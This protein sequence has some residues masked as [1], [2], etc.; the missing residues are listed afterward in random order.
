MKNRNARRWLRSERVPKWFRG[1]LHVIMYAKIS[2]VHSMLRAIVMEAPRKK[3]L[4]DLSISGTHY[5][6]IRNKLLGMF[7]IGLI[8]IAPSPEPAQLSSPRQRLQ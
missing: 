3:T 1:V 2:E 4:K 7:W 8:S 6:R 5:D